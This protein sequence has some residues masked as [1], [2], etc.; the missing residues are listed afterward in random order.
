M[1][2]NKLHFLL[3]PHIGPGHT[4]PMIDM[5]KLLAKQ[6][7]VTVTIATTPLN[8]TR[9]GA[10]LTGPIES[11]LPVRFLELPF[12]TAEAGLPEGCSE[13]VKN[14]IEK[15]MDD[16]I[17]GNERRKRAKELG[18]IANGAIKEGGSSHLNLTL[19]IQDIMH[20]TKTSS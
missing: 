7:N 16:G 20:Y 17:E 8:A 5:A 14:A 19:L 11:G 1:S 6:P 3:I 2:P 9:Y 4:I 18:K 12:P 15:V 10:T 13:S